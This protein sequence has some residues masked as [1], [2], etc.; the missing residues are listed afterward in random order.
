MVRLIDPPLNAAPP[1]PGAVAT[2]SAVQDRRR[3]GRAED[4][5]SALLPL[6]RDPVQCVDT[7]LDI[8]TDP[9]APARGVVFGLLLSV[10]VWALVGL[11]VW[12]I[13]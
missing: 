3:P 5:S 12:L 10:L 6:L 9:L 1:A 8:D 11:G 4:V 7:D 13:L 2:P